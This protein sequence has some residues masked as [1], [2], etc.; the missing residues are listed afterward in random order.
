M[1]LL[2][3]DLC[4]I[5]AGSGGLSVAAG[6]AQMGASVVLLEADK[7]GGDCLNYGCVPSKALIASAHRAESMR[8]A[9]E[10][11]IENHTPTINFESV[12]SHLNGVIK[13]IEPH[14]SAERFE[15][16]GVHVI[17]EKGTFIDPQTVQA[18][19]HQIKARTFIIATGS[20]ANIPAIEGLENTPYLTNATIFSINELPKHLIILG[21]GP[22]GCEM[23]QAFRRLGSEVTLLQRSHILHKE[24][25]ELVAPII[26]QLKK[27]GV[28]LLENTQIQKA[29]HTNG[30]TRITFIQDGVTKTVTGSHLLVS[31][32]QKPHM[33][34]LNLEAGNILHTSRGITVNAR[35][36]TSNKHVYAIGDVIGGPQFTHAAG[37]HAGIVLRNAL[38]KLPA[39][40]SYT[41]LPR[42]TYTDPELAQVGLTEPEAEAQNIKFETFTSSFERNDRALCEG[43]PEGFIKILVTPKGKILGASI[44]GNHAGELISPWTLAIQEGL[45]VKAL[46]QCIVS[47]PTLSEINKR[48]ASEYFIPK[49]ASASLKRVVSVLKRL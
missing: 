43:R 47:Y 6:A 12:S 8:T 16:L 5:G 35:L 25:P 11:G 46:A 44:V 13:T 40:V 23:G 3:P 19:D 33:K 27:E 45:G 37:Y 29:E 49:L 21:G 18:G 34:P 17:K 1:P 48:A 28:T 26:E 38:F 39:K 4:I 32:G 22:I 36:R 42:V 7:M 15:S 14:D 9:K 24:D 41:A 30:E 20:Q 31:A 10:V 2:K